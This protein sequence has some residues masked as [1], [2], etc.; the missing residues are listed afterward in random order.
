MLLIELGGT[1]PEQVEA[2]LVSA[3]ELCVEHGAIEV[4]IAEDRNTMERIWNVRRNIAE[5]LKIYSP[6]QS[7]EDSVVPIASIPEIIP[8]LERLSR[9]YGIT[10][11]CYGHAVDGNLHAT[12]R[13]KNAIME[14]A[15]RLFEARGFDIVTIVD[16]TKEAKVAKSSFYTYF[17]TKSDIIVDEFLKID[18][19]YHEYAAKN[20]ERYRTAH[21]KLL[22]F[23]RAQLRYVRD[24]IGNANLKILYANQTIQPGTDKIIANKAR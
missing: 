4:F 2:D 22:A 11:P 16:I 18:G 7:L 20:L 1:N 10:I 14:S 13:T 23:T 24:V 3:G 15:L 17:S 6:N 8:E 12:L 19:Y 9:K 21:E 5:A